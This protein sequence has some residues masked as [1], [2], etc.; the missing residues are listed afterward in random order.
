[1]VTNDALYLSTD[2]IPDNIVKEEFVVT[3]LHQG[4]FLFN[5]GLVNSNRFLLKDGKENCS[6]QSSLNEV[7]HFN[8]YFT[9]RNHSCGK[10]QGVPPAA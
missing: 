6:T 3:V 2:I 9:T 4:R 5:V 7:I 1:M 8:N 10:Q